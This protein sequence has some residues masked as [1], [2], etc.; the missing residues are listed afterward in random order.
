M[1]TCRIEP[2][3]R[4]RRR[5]R[6][7]NGI[8]RRASPRPHPTAISAN[9]VAAR[10]TSTRSALVLPASDVASTR[11][12]FAIAVAATRLTASAASTRTPPA[13]L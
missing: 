1:S 4:T 5:P 13:T 12:V 8:S 2:G 11:L 3:Y 7:A 10:P 9:T 6:R